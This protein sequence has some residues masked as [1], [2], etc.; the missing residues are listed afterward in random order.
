MIG[1]GI[2]LYIGITYIHDFE[3]K[4]VN[5]FMQVFVYVFKYHIC[6]SKYGF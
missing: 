1:I 5:V 2:G 4:T 6:I 3:R